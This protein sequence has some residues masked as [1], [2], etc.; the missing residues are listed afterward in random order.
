MNKHSWEVVK[1]RKYNSN[2]KYNEE[3][4]KERIE[5][6]MYSSGDSPKWVHYIVAMNTY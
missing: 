6:M 2:N 4:Q 5:M 1:L 3:E